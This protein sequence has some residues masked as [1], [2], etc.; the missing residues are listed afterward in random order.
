MPKLEEIFP[1]VVIM[2][3]RYD[4]LARSFEIIFCDYFALDSTC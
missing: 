1:I 2:C 4:R 3:H